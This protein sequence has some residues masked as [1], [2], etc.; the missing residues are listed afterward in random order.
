MGFPCG[1]AGKESACSAGD[2]GL[3]PVLEIS[4]WR[5]K[6]YSLQYSGLENAMDCIVH[7]IEKSRTRL[8]DFDF[9]SLYFLYN[10]SSICGHSYYLGLWFFVSGTSYMVS[11]FPVHYH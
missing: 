5:R 10:V 2:L 3:I 1:S 6:G 9:T 11:A 8:S 4:P 7:G